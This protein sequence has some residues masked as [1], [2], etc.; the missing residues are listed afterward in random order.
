M[1]VGDVVNITEQ[2]GTGTFYDEIPLGWGIILDIEET[3]DVFYGGFGPFNLGDW[4]TVQLA[5]GDMK[6]FNNKS[7]EVVCESNSN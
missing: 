2:R 6:R 7:L 5:S 1:K 4:V 3:E